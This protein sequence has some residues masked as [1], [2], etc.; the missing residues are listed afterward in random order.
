[1][2]IF[3]SCPVI[4][5]IFVRALRARAGFTLLEIMVALSLMAIVLVTVFNMHLQTINMNSF[6]KFDT[7]APMLAQKK[8]A[9]IEKDALKD[10]IGDSGEFGD[11]YP[12]FTWLV[13][14]EGIESEALGEVAGDVKKIDITVSF[15]NDEFIYNL[16]TYRLVRD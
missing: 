16:R 4:P 8:M 9:E 2:K 10:S 1:M 3:R 14:V 7:I 12:G 13:S 15:N 11:K 5:V 6:V